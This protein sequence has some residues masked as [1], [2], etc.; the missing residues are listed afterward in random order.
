MKTMK[1]MKNYSVILFAT[2]L[3]LLGS[4]NNDDPTPVNEEEVITTVRLTFTP[5]SGGAV[6]IAAWRDLDGDGGNAPV[7]D[8]IS[9]EANTI[10]SMSVQFLNEQESPA[11]DITK[12]VD[13]ENR[14]HQ[15]F[16]VNTASGLTI[17][18]DD[19]DTDSKPVGLKNIATTT[20]VGTGTLKVILKHE[21]NKSA[22]GVA[23]GDVTN[24][25]G[26][27]DVETNPAFAVTIQ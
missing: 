1:T 20:A 5:N 3:L 22:A 6:V 11:D 19:V 7:V 27:T 21:P 15:V 9:L 14:E 10:Y 18:Y 25:G 16:F 2:L 13:E 4:C 26:D 23:N 24:A 12:E 8:P 17:K